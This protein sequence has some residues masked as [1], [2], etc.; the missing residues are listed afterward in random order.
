MWKRYHQKIPIQFT[1]H[2][3]KTVSAYDPKDNNTYKS[4]ISTQKQ[5]SSLRGA[6]IAS[7]IFTTSK[8]SEES[9]LDYKL[10]TLMRELDIKNKRIEVMRQE[11]KDLNSLKDQRSRHKQ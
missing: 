11:L 9:K 3:E 4:Q 8:A 1:Q 2:L 5:S 10:Q 6:N 7:Q